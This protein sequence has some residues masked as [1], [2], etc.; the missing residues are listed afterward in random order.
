M[1]PEEK[2][3][4]ELV[5]RFDFEVTDLDG[6]TSHTRDEAKQC[7]LI[8]VDEQKEFIKNWT[9]IDW[10]IRKI[11]IDELEEVKQEIQKL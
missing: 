6:I 4:R 5:E 7:A 3:A 9:G 10:N 8:C 1:T 11:M 2:K